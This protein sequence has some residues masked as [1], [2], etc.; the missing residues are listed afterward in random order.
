MENLKNI[1]QLVD[2]LTKNG[3]SLKAIKPNRFDDFANRKVHL[4][5]FE[6]LDNGRLSWLY[7]DGVS[8]GYSSFNKIFDHVTIV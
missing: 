6:V 3:K 7:D 5:T 2:Y 1:E 8:T 4:D